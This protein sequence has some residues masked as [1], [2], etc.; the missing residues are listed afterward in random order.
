MNCIFELSL[1]LSMLKKDSKLYPIL[2][3]KCPRCHEGDVFKAG[4]SYRFSKITEMN[5][6]CP[7]CNLKFEREPGFFYGA[8][9]VSYAL[10][11]A[12]WVA[13]AVAFFVLSESIDPWLFMIVGIG[14]L[15][16][17]LPGIYRLSR[18]IWLTMFV[19]YEP[20]EEKKESG[21]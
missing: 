8:M 21:S 15:L 14:L 11:V 4:F 20:K 17:L 2:H 7:N 3:L 13:V 16:I 12:L 6:H 18:V 10:T 19:A 5:T 1:L 9:Y